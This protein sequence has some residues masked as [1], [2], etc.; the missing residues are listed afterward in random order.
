MGSIC[1]E[2]AAIAEPDAGRAGKH[3]ASR[4]RRG[5]LRVPSCHK[6]GLTC[7]PATTVVL[8]CMSFN[9]CPVFVLLPEPTFAMLPSCRVQGGVGAE[10][11][12]AAAASP[13]RA[14]PNSNRHR[15][16]PVK[17]GVLHA[18]CSGQLRGGGSAGGRR[19]RL[20]PR[21]PQPSGR[22]RVPTL[23]LSHS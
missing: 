21:Q 2:G 20:R 3:R 18:E 10:H 4:V 22:C 16:L 15:R 12:A 19:Q 17:A 11:L 23:K 9:S 7:N 6:Q 13:A 8:A 14:V 1:A 5:T